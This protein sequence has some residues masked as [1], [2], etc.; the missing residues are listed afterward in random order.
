M[1][2]FS[3]GALAYADFRLALRM[4]I[5]ERVAVVEISAL[6]FSEWMPMLKALETLDLASFRYVSIHLPSRMTIQE[7][8]EVL[9]SLLGWNRWPLILHPDAVH[10]WHLWREFGDRICVENMDVR[11]P[12]GR[13][14]VELDLIFGE[15]PEAR[16]CF[17]IGHAWQVDPTMGEAYRILKRFGNRLTQIHMSE[18][19]SQSKHDALSYSTIQSFRDIADMIPADIPVILETPVPQEEMR[20]EINKAQFALMPTAVSHLVA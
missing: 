5:E 6:R 9:A 2:G 1:I 17:D 14:D 16:L 11:K 20:S 7:E 4:L 12:I 18:V 15:L 8:E 3:T 10:H 19:N 13:T